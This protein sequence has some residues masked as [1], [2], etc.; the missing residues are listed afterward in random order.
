MRAAALVVVFVGLTRLVAA[1]VGTPGMP[2]IA[3]LWLESCAGMPVRLWRIF[4][5]LDDK[6][7]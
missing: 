7:W 3:G 2:P 1:V 6:N 4:H 5:L